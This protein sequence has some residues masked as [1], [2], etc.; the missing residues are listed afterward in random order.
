M[1]ARS[2]RVQEA[3][4]R[5][6]A[7]A[8]RIVNPP[9]VPSTHTTE[10]AGALRPSLSGG[11]LR[12]LAA[13]LIQDQLLRI[14]RAAH[15]VEN[16]LAALVHRLV[17]RRVHRRLGYRRLAD[18][19][20]DRPGL[21]LAACRRLVHRDRSPRGT[22]AGTALFPAPPEDARAPGTAPPAAPAAAVPASSRNGTAEF[23]VWMEVTRTVREALQPLGPGT[24]VDTPLPPSPPAATRGGAYPSRIDEADSGPGLF[25]TAR[26]DDLGLDAAIGDRVRRAQAL[27]WRRARLLAAAARHHLYK[28]LGFASLDDWAV[29]V[30]GLSPAGVGEI[31]GMERILRSHPCIED[32]FRRGRLTWTRA[33]QAARAARPET[34]RAWVRDARRL[35]IARLRRAVDAALGASRTASY[36][37]RQDDRGMTRGDP[38]TGSRITSASAS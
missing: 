3:F 37:P 15:A 7:P 34:E 10:A 30:A 5:T 11:P 6:P 8:G 9:L 12:L 28:E 36:R 24:G 22:T 26:E 32:A 20:E 17:A 21:P 2:T 33:L 29:A 38:V 1:S 31:L 13:R 19:L 16:D 23:D 25:E 4:T 14:G 35:P 18:Y 27:A